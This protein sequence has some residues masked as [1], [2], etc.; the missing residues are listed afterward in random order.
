MKRR[1]RRTTML[2]RKRQR[3]FRRRYGRYRRG[4]SRNRSP[5]VKYYT[6][7]SPTTLSIPSREPATASADLPANQNFYNDMIGNISLGTDSTNRIGQSIFVKKIVIYLYPYLCPA[8]RASYSV[9]QSLLRVMV[10]GAREPAGTTC[11][12]FFHE[13]DKWPDLGFIDRRNRPVHYDKW[14]DIQATQPTTSAQ[15]MQGKVRRIVIPFRVNRRCVF[16]ST[17]AVKED[18]NCFSLQ[19]AAI[20]PAYAEITDATQVFCTAWSYRVYFTDD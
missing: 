16:T 14:F 18:S 6:Y 15:I 1:Y 19:M 11:T 12:S 10:T 5:E 9:N 8:N 13:A 20:P 7:N 2:L 17:G 4:I 3:H